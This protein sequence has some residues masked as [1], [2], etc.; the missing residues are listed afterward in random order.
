MPLLLIDCFQTGAGGESG[1]R[2]QGSSLRSTFPLLTRVGFLGKAKWEGARGRRARRA[3]IKALPAALHHPR[4]YGLTS[5][6]PK[7]LPVRALPL[8]T[9]SINRH[10]TGQ[11]TFSV[12][13]S[14]FY[15]TASANIISLTCILLKRRDSISWSLRI[16][17]T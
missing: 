7:N 13:T 10:S 17:Q 1:H 3:T 9:C 11:S 4:P 5:T 16:S 15:L 2:P 6:F 12:I 14:P 8:P